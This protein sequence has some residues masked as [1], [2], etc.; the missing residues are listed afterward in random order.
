MAHTELY[1]ALGVSPNASEDELRRVSKRLTCKIDPDKND[2]DTEAEEQ[3]KIISQAYEILSDPEKREMYDQYGE[4]GMNGGRG[5]PG[6]DFDMNDLF[7]SFMGGHGGGGRPRPRGPQKTPSVRLDLPVTLEDL[8]LGKVIKKSLSKDVVC[9]S[10]KG[11]GGKSPKQCG[12]CEGQGVRRVVRAVGPGMYTQGIVECGSC[13]GKG[14]T[15]AAKDKCK[16]CKGA[17]VVQESKSI[18]IR[19]EKGMRDGTKIV[20]AGEADQKPDMLAGDVVIVLDLQEHPV[21]TVVGEDLE[22][23]LE[24]TLAEALCGFTRYIKHLDGRYIEIVH[25]AGNVIEPRQVK[26]V[27]GEGMPRVRRSGDKGNLYIKFAVTFPTSPMELSEMQTN[28]LRALLPK[29]AP[30]AKPPKAAIVD[31]VTLTAEGHRD[32]SRGGKS[33]HHHGATHSDDDEWDDE[34][35]GQQGPGCAQ[36]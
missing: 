6:D 14:T 16:K 25:P 2:G 7:A 33:G 20:L 10:C 30:V 8:Y 19:V 21:F 23:T 9:G 15:F 36:Q 1:D 4:E 22:T 12:T 5:G 26:C 27:H 35:E 29:A 34:D 18:E 13:H 32:G 11:Y 31:P 17:C 24:I 3:F 28:Q